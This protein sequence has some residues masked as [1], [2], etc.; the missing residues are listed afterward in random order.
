[1]ART[2]ILRAFGLQMPWRLSL[3][4]RLFGFTCFRLYAFVEA[5]A[6]CLIVLQ[7]AGAPIATRVS[8]FLFSFRDVP[9]NFVHSILWRYVTLR[10]VCFVSLRFVFML[11]LKPRP[12][13]QSSFDMQEALR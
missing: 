12:F 6:L 1:M 7:Y 2:C 3:V 9:I 13:V 11:S 8:F 5:A 4:L 10:Y